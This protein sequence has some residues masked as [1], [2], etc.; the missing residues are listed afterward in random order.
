MTRRCP[1]HPASDWGCIRDGCRRTPHDHARRHGAQGVSGRLGWKRSPR[2]GVG[3]QVVVPHQRIERVLRAPEHE[4]VLATPSDDCDFAGLDGLQFDLDGRAQRALSL[5]D[6]D[7]T[8]GTALATRPV[9][10][11][12]VVARDPQPAVLVDGGGR[13]RTLAFPPLPIP[14]C[15][16]SDRA[17]R[18]GIALPP[19]K[20]LDD[21]APLNQLSS[22]QHAMVTSVVAVQQ[23]LV[24][25]ILLRNDRS[26]GHPS[27]QHLAWILRQLVFG[28]SSSLARPLPD[29]EQC[30]TDHQ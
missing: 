21:A 26:T 14:S 8:N 13:R 19:G 1:A 29:I 23:D 11:R 5:G 2:S 4:H 30:G 24:F 12:T 7:A 25:F 17:H 18:G 3:Q 16:A 6:S 28:P 27:A 22:V 10:P 9:P 15:V 20:M